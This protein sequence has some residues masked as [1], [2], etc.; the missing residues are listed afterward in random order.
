MNGDQQQPK[1]PPQQPINFSPSGLVNP[2]NPNPGIIA[3]AG[4]RG[5]APERFAGAASTITPVGTGYSFMTGS[6]SKV[7][8]AGT[9]SPPKPG[10]QQRP[11][12]QP[13]IS[14]GQEGP[15][16]PGEYF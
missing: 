11:V 6:G 14:P 8:V 16:G 15:S 2:F 3:Q 13:P 7:D 1:P 10:Q 9:P 4:Q 5:I 12:Y